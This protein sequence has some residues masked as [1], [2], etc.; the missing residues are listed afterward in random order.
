MTENPLYARLKAN[1][2]SP[3]ILI[4]MMGTGKTALAK[5][6]AEKIGQQAIDI[7]SEI[8]KRAGLTIPEIFE[9]HGEES[10]RRLEFDVLE[11]ILNAAKEQGACPII[12]TGGGIVTVP[13][14]AA[15]IK[16]GGVSVW[17]KADL[18]HL[19][20]RLALDKSR[21]MLEGAEN[22]KARLTELMRVRE[23]LYAAADITFVTHQE[24]LYKTVPLLAEALLA[25]F[26]AGA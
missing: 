13:E 18:D 22:V 24:P 15:L 23:P 17:L 10:F 1:L 12:A 16:K 3:V 21:P 11:S 14:C 4:G 2:S 8:V 19:A 25:H 6:L 26:D 5:K 9:K 7:D 20:A